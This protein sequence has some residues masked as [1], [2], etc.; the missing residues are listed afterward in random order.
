[1]NPLTVKSPFTFVEQ[2]ITPST[3]YIPQT[4]DGENDPEKIHRISSSF[5]HYLSQT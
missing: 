4:P 2:T 5:R 1:M 3:S